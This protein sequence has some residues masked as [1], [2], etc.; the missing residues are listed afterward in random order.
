M[1]PVQVGFIHPVILP[2]G[3]DNRFSVHTEICHGSE[4]T[5]FSVNL[6]IGMIP[7]RENHRLPVFIKI[8]FP[9]QAFLPVVFPL[10]LRIPG[11]RQ[12]RFAFR[13][14][15]CF[16]NRISVLILLSYDCCV[17]SRQAHR[18]PSCVKVGYFYRIAFG[19]CPCKGVF[20]SRKR[21]QVS[22]FII[23][24]CR[25]GVSFIVIF[26]FCTGISICG[27]DLIPVCIQIDL[28]VG[29]SVFIVC[30]LNRLV[31]LCARSGIAFGIIIPFQHNMAFF[32]VIPF[33][34]CI[35]GCHRKRLL[36]QEICNPAN[37]I[38]LVVFLPYLVVPFLPGDRFSVSIKIL[39]MDH[40]ALFVIFT[41]QGSIS[42]YQRE[43][44]TIQPIFDSADLIP[45]VVFLSDFVVPF[46]ACNG[47]SVRVKV[48]LT[49]H[50]ALFVIIPCQRSI[51]VC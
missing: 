21:N 32:V 14:K 30:R 45:L 17:S 7:I 42:I 29:F 4:K 33:Q 35:S 3:V 26:I 15:V 18:F 2:P 47:I 25:C 40:I 20:P 22:V 36:A 31:S 5:V 44:F 41:F 43:R 23:I 8:A 1:A 37:L 39:F 6:R 51:S 24:E 28:F 11:G 48:L 50:I 27:Q 38:V 12:H 49:D 9:G 13:V 46:S 10:D 34:C 19:D 16:F